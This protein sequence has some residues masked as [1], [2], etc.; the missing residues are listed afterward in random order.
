M[1]LKTVIDPRIATITRQEH[2]VTLPP[3]CPVTGNPE[4]GELA[5]S[6]VPNGKL[7]EVYALS[8]YIAGF[9]GNKEVRDIEH[10][11]EVVARDCAEVLGV[12]VQVIGL[13]KLNIG[14]TVK[15]E[16]AAS[17]HL[18]ALKEH[19]SAGDCVSPS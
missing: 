3:L 6:Y 10:L 12:A 19:C 18:P 8:D 11:T 17:P 15:V 2:I 1:G 13:F 5:I 14:Q 9:V 16:V 7:L 4:A